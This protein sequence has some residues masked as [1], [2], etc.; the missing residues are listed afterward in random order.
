VRG[1]LDPAVARVRLAVRRSLAD[2]APGAVVLVGCSGGADSL[3]LLA[4][5]CFEAPRAGLRPAAVVVDHGLQPGSAQVAQQAAAQ[6]VRLGAADVRVERV[7]VPPRGGPEGAARTAR[8]EALDRVAA[9]LGAACLLLAHTRD[10][11]AETVLLGLARGSGARS[12]SGMRPVAGLVRRPLLGLPRDDTRAACTAAGL[13]WWDDPHNDDPAHARA[14]VR[15]RLLPALERELGPGVRDALARSA[16]LLRADAD[17]LDA[18]AAGLLE[19]A[20]DEAAEP[21]E[22][23]VDVLSR[24]PAAVRQR[25]LHRAALA[26]GCPAGDLSATHVLAMDALVTGWHGQRG[27]DLPGRV[28]AWRSGGSLRLGGRP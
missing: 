22:L 25:V 2:L 12:L 13:T 7:R 3:A 8:R 17:A 11:Q 23:S 6:A 1:R 20:R 5:T 21:P 14:R 18:L 4:A 24:A 19:T 28:Q 10:D 27:V 9:E 26:A 16:D 15:H